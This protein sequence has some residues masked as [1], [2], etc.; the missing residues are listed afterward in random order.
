MKNL[1][2]LLNE[3]DLKVH[4][5]NDD[6]V[7]TML[8]DE[9][10]AEFVHKDLHFPTGFKEGGEALRGKKCAS[11]DG[12]A[13]RLIYFFRDSEN[14]KLV[15]IDGDKQFVLI[16]MYIQDLLDKLAITQDQ[17]SYVLVQTAYVNSRATKFVAAKGIYNELCPTGVKNAHPIVQR[18]DIGANDEPNG[19]GTVT[20]HMHKVETAL[21]PYLAEGRL[22]AKKVLQLLRISNLCVGDAIANVL[23]LEAIMKDLD[24]SI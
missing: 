8:N 23:V 3:G 15:I 11:F 13:D 5:Y 6:L 10:G 22:E 19:H 14:D 4:F 7:P 12:D 20:A 16:S 9:C 18:F 2:K 1:V 21:A 17:L 24:M